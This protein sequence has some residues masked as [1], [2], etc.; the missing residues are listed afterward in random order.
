MLR[1]VLAWC[2]IHD[3]KILQDM[4]QYAMIDQSTGVFGA[5]DMQRMVEFE[6]VWSPA[7]CEAWH[8]DGVQGQVVTDPAQAPDG[9]MLFGWQNSDPAVP[10][11][12]GFHDESGGRPY[13][14]LL[15]DPFM[16][17][18]GG[19]FDGGS[20][21]ESLLGVHELAETLLDAYIDEWVQM[22]SGLFLAKEASDPVQA[23][24]YLLTHPDGGMGLG[25]DAV[26]PRYFDQQAPVDGTVQFDLAGACSAPFQLM[27][28]GY[29]IVFDPRQVDNG[30]GGVSNVYG[31]RAPDWLKVHKERAAGRMMCRRG[32]V[33]TGLSM[34]QG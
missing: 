18:G 25:S 30:Q 7:F 32:R 26:L 14:V 8:L 17:A 29:Q 34:Q 21:G 4:F 28:G 11:A 12:A 19:V 22:P 9:T 15:T 13:A 1:L 31:E 6:Q 3:E 23:V 10:G 20:A 5:G 24:Q 2:A 33:I 16:S 27:S